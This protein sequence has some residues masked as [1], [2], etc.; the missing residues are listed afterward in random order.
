MSKTTDKQEKRPWVR[1]SGCSGRLGQTILAGGATEGG[2]EER[3]GAA[4]FPVCQ[5]KETMAGDGR[6]IPKGNIDKERVHR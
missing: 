1:C 2:R 4:V 5:C 6:I 3:G